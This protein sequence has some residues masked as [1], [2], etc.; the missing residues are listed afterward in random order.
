MIRLAGIVAIGLALGALWGLPQAHAAD[1]VDGVWEQVDED[2]TVGA[3]ITITDR[4]GVID[5]VISKVL[6][7]KDPVPETCEKCS[8]AKKG[9]KIVGLRIIE[10][11]RRDGDE[12]TG[13]TITDPKNGK[14]YTARMRL[15]ADGRTLDVRGYIGT[16]L[17]GRSQTWRR[18]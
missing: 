15:S 17:L 18:H 9:A 12:Y 5:G 4:N 10:N 8:G 1:P 3:L 14:E 11:M 7:R 6:P 2:G 16:P 13:G